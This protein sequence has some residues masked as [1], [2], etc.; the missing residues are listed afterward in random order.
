MSNNCLED[1]GEDF[2]LGQERNYLNLHPGQIYDLDEQCRIVFGPNSFFIVRNKCIHN[3]L[4][5]ITL[6]IS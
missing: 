5:S 2:D 4:I 1:G 6:T 3:T